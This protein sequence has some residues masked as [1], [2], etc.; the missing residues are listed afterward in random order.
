[1][2][3]SS[4]YEGNEFLAREERLGS[5]TTLVFDFGLKRR[6]IDFFAGLAISFNVSEIFEIPKS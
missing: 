3:N 5:R 2:P 6:L 1:V 4:A